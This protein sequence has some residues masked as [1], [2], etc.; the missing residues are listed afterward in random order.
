MFL[1]LL[2]SLNSQAL[3]HKRLLA[4]MGDGRCEMFKKCACINGMEILFFKV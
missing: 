4:V 1:S 2:V 3:K